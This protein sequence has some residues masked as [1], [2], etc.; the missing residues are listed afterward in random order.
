[1]IAAVIVGLT[2]VA[3]LAVSDPP[4][5][6]RDLRRDQ[7]LVQRLNAIQASIASFYRSNTKLP[8]TLAD[9]LASPQ[10]APYGVTAENLKEVDYAPGDDAKTYRLCATFLRASGTDNVYVA[11][12]WKHDAGHQCFPLKASDK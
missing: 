8:A 4:W 5:V 3:A 7:N 6:V 9:L 12:N 10:T 2:I 11:Q 1:V